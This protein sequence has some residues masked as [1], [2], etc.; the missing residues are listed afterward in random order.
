MAQFRHKRSVPSLVPNVD[1][2]RYFWEDSGG[3]PK[4]I[5][6]LSI[7]M[8][9]PQFGLVHTQALYRIEAPSLP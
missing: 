3:L 8:L 4:L 6:P 7:R 2:N 1:N 5:S 9:N